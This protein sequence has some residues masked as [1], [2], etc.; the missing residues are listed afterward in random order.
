MS[1]VTATRF[2]ANAPSASGNGPQRDPITLISLITMVANETSCLPAMVLF[3]I[4]VPRGRTALRASSR[5]DAEPV[6]S[7]T[8]SNRRGCQSFNR[9]FRD[10]GMNPARDQRGCSPPLETPFSCA[11]RKQRGILD[12]KAPQFVLSHVE[13]L[14]EGLPA[15][16]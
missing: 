11:R 9:A 5:P 14:R 3:R 15:P 1:G 13:G 2:A 4:N 16:C 6:A 7:T 8:M 12:S 10:R